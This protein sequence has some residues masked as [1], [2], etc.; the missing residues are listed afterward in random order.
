MNRSSLRLAANAAAQTRARHD[1]DQFSPGTIGERHF[2]NRGSVDEA[3]MA[4]MNELRAQLVATQ[5]KARGIRDPLV[6]GAM[7]KVARE[8]FVPKRLRSVAYQDS[9]LPIGAG[10]TI[11]QPYMVALMVEA[12][13]LRGGEMVLEIG[14][15]SGYAAAVL[16]EIARA[17][18]TIE[19]IGQLAESAAA[20]LAAAGCENVQ[21]RHADG[22]QGWEYNAPFD[23]ILVSA[24]APGIPKTLMRQLAVGGRMVI[25]IGRNQKTQALMLITR[26]GEDEF[27]QEDIAGVRFVPLIGK[28]GWESRWHRRKAS[29]GYS[30]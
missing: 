3:Q 15:G 28:E 19:R 7:G 24:G 16:S 27:E 9:P 18:F 17:V 30:I 21:V 5:V 14:A 25:P 2:S 4:S 13:A 26:V 8:L 23:A 29:S 11:S 6:L 10:Q 20:N 1:P 12:L 22:T